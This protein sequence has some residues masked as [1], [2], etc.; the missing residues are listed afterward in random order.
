MKPTA[1]FPPAA[2]AVIRGVMGELLD[3]IID[4]DLRDNCHGCAIDHPSQLQHACLFGPEAY[5]LHMN[6]FRLLKKLFKPWLKYTLVKAL[7]L[8]GINHT[9]SLD[10][11]LGIAEA[12]IC[13]WRDEPNIK[14]VVNKLKKKTKEI[15]SDQVYEDVV[16]YWTFHSSLDP[17]EPSHTWETSKHATSILSPRKI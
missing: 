6:A 5:Y 14:A 2:L 11:I 3:R 1:V 16:D 8:S 7:K 9:P 4:R 15:C 17:P 10:K 13:D 12:T